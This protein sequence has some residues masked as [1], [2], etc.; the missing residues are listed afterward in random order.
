ML[1]YRDCQFTSGG[2]KKRI[3]LLLWDFL[4]SVFPSV[5]IR[6]TETK[7]EDLYFNGVAQC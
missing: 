3:E 4:A 2:G 6:K 7:S 1:Y 5:N